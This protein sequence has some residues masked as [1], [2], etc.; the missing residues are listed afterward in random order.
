MTRRANKRHCEDLQQTPLQP[1]PARDIDESLRGHQRCRDS[2]NHQVVRWECSLAGTCRMQA[3]MVTS[4]ASVARY[5]QP[6]EKR[7]VRGEPSG[8]ELREEPHALR[9]ARLPLCE[10]P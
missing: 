2:G 9:F 4:C 6:R 5:R 8:Y 10:K 7:I 3:S 1:R